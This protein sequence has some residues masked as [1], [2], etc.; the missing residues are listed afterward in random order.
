M[1]DEDS[2]LASILAQFRAPMSSVLSLI[3]IAL[4]SFW[5]RRLRWIWQSGEIIQGLSE[6]KSGSSRAPR[7]SSLCCS[8]ALAQVKAGLGL[9]TLDKAL[10]PPE[11]GVA[12]EAAQEL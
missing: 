5:L 12:E 3:S 11:L 2:V 7:K 8:S 9:V 6:R 10:L 1:S 4:L